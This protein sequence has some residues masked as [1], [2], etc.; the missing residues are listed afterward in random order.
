MTISQIIRSMNILSEKDIQRMNTHMS[1][2]KYIIKDV[3][4]E[5]IELKHDWK[6]KGLKVWN[7]GLLKTQP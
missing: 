6:K 5:N 1:Q 2:N 4:K 3:S 7:K